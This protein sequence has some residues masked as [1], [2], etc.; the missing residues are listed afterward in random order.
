M[1]ERMAVMSNGR[2]A[3]QVDSATGYSRA[4]R[5][6]EA[7]ANAVAGLPPL[8]P[9]HPDTLETVRVIE[10]GGLFGGIAGL[11][12]LYVRVARTHD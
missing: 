4:M 8:R 5:F 12:Q 11:N 9:D 7:F 3:A 1:D 2:R 10:I 6:D